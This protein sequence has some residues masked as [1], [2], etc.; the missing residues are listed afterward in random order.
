M[1]PGTGV[2]ARLL[3]VEGMVLTDT[4][5]FFGDQARSVL[6]LE[7]VQIFS[8]SLG[9]GQLAIA[10]TSELFGSGLLREGI[11]EVMAERIEPWEWRYSDHSPKYYRISQRK[12]EC[13]WKGIYHPRL[14]LQC[15]LLPAE[16]R[17]RAQRPRQLSMYF[18]F[19]PLKGCVQGHF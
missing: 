7:S 18:V 8:I 14:H 13:R 16:S 9:W 15:R 5:P 19:A 1:A 6:S 4:Q 12:G 10:I 2:S 11:K 17:N 3:D